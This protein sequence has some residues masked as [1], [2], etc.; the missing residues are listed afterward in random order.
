M[1]NTCVLEF[2]GYITYAPGM[3]NSQQFI[4]IRSFFF[5]VIWV[6]SFN[7]SFLLIGAC[8]FLFFDYVKTINMLSIS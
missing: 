3:N 4:S 7:F 2:Y 6:A 5:S 1:L 8:V